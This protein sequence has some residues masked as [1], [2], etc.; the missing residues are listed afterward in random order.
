MV[1]ISRAYNDIARTKSMI[2]KIQRERA[3][4]YIKMAAPEILDNPITAN[5]EIMTV[6]NL[7]ES[8]ADDQAL[9]NYF[10]FLIQKTNPEV[11]QGI[12]RQQRLEYLKEARAQGYL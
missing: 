7:M 11:A 2:N 12:K 10:D 1:S 6:T 5:R 4:R 9:V 8:G 3:T